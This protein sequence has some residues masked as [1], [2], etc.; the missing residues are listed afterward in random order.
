MQHTR[1]Q[2]NPC[3]ENKKWNRKYWT[4]QVFIITSSWKWET[5]QIQVNADCSPL[6]FL[7]II[8][9]WQKQTKLN[10]PNLDK[11][12]CLMFWNCW[13]YCPCTET[14]ILSNYQSMM[15]KHWKLSLNWRASILL[16]PLDLLSFNGK[17]TQSGAKMQTAHILY[18]FSHCFL[19]N[20]VHIFSSLYKCTVWN[21]VKSNKNTI[22]YFTNK[23]Q[24]NLF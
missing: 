7:G 13:D 10:R 3:T 24:L 20:Q 9:H 23:F 6:P 12:S 1:Q 4:S 15:F 21:M 5:I 14:A 19:S 18:I 8:I 11:L 22:R 17:Y 16:K 2:R